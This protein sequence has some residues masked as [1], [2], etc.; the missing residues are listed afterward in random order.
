MTKL[1]HLAKNTLR[2]KCPNTEFFVVRVFPYTD[3]IRR[4]TL[5]ISAFSPNTGL[6][7]GKY[8]PEITPYLDTFHAVNSFSTRA[9]NLSRV[10]L[11]QK[12]ECCF[13]KCSVQT[14]YSMLCRRTSPQSVILHGISLHNSSQST[15]INSIWTTVCETIYYFT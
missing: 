3:S 1:F 5:W 12:Y 13:C 2:E 4:S 7:T 11:R 15:T 9:M 14:C 8:E 10:L 6:N